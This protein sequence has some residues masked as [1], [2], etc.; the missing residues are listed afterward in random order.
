MPKPKIV[1]Y[2]GE[3]AIRDIDRLG[4]FGEMGYLS[5]G[6]PWKTVAPGISSLFCNLSQRHGS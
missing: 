2:S 1:D 6:D 5:V 4:L 3:H